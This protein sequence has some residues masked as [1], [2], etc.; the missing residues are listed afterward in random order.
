[1]KRMYL[2]CVLFLT[3]VCF[4]LTA[5]ASESAIHSVAISE[6]AVTVSVTA[7]A[8]CALWC[9]VYEESG[10][11]TAA[12]SE[13]VSG[14]TDAQTV[15]LSFDAIPAN[16]YVKAF[17]LD[18]TFR[19]LCVAGDARND[20]DPVYTSDVYAI[21][22]ADG[23]LVFQH[24]NTPRP[25]LEVQATYAV[26]MEER[27][28]YDYQN[29]TPTTPWY[30]DRDSIKQFE[31]AD[32][33]R[34][35]SIEYW[36]YGY[37]NLEG[38]SNLNY[39]DTSN[40]TDMYKLFYNCSSLRALDFGALNTSNVTN[41]SRMF[42]NCSSLR[43]LDLNNCNTS[44]VTDLDWMFHN[45]RSLTELDLGDFDTSKVTR[46]GRMF[47]NCSS[48]R[49]LNLSNFNT[50]KARDMYAMFHNCRSLTELDLSNFNTTRVTNMGL[51]FYNCSSLTAL[52]LSNF[53]TSGVTDM[54]EMFYNCSSLTALDLSNF[55]TSMVTNMNAMFD[56][57]SSLTAL[58]VSNFNV[59]SVT[60]MSCM[61]YGCT[62]LVSID[63]SSF[64]TERVNNMGLMFSGCS[65]LVTI[66]ASEQF[67]TSRAGSSSGVFNDCRSLVGGA[68]TR[69]D[70]SH[71]DIGYA[72]I[73]GG[74][75]NP[76]YFT[77][78]T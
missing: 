61:F 25:G 67:A 8:D 23:T 75:D 14:A 76:G 18:N 56:N 22:Y 19:P 68:G 53:N 30:H 34:P 64:N 41:M 49:R 24:G 66:Y 16:A 31:F 17:L 42:Y 4:S 1:M 65:A 9:A 58:D 70:E 60:N 36:F 77:A 54:G 29:G 35:Q 7:Q 27:Y 43:T 39:L 28:Y 50:S 10:K 57:C 3:A 52:D 46:M 71:G 32:K 5:S 21:L 48:L 51:M 6:N 55:N 13:N 20:N 11:M 72:H 37:S 33:I 38:I 63:L 74:L 15:T 59:S 44:N 47:Y 12:T 2:F 40:I 78:K 45:C 62:L 26:D 69:Y 73:D